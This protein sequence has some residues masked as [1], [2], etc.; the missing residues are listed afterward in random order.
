MKKTFLLI[1]ISAGMIACDAPQKQAGNNM[2]STAPTE[3][4]GQSGVIDNTSNPNIVQTAVKSK[5]HTT[6][7][8]AVKAAGLVDALSNAGPFTVFAPT[9]A[10]FDELPKGTVDE[11]LKPEKKN[12]LSNILEYHTYVGSLSTTILQ[13]G[14]QFEEVNGQKIKISKKG[15]KIMVN[16]AEILATIPTSNGIIHV[17]NKV[18]LPPAK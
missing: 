10:A 15:D 5:D 9:N 13:D 7:V 2:E 16:D 18:L 8:A 11:L 12:D 14:Q 6:L 4:V 1:A 3:S 17:I